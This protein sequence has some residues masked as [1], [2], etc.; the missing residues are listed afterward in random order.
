MA[1]PTLSMPAKAP[2]NPATMRVELH[3]DTWVPNPNWVPGKKDQTEEESIRVSCVAVDDEGNPRSED[4]G[5]K[6]LEY[7]KVDLPYD[8]AVRLIKAKKAVRA[9]SF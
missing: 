3:Y 5:L 2:E 4:H 8:L 6:V 9:E 7:A 1:N